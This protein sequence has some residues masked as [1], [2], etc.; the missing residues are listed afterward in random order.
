VLHPG[1]SV[2]ERELREHCSAR[3]AP[4]KVPKT[5]SFAE[6]LPRG[7]TGKLVRH[8]LTSEECDID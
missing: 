2:D 8:E 7:E 4:F 6:R 3:L 5:F 1:A